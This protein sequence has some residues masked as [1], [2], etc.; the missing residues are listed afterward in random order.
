[1]PSLRHGLRPLN[2]DGDVLK[3]V[4]DVKGFE[5]IEIYVEHMTDS[6]I[7]AQGQGRLWKL[8]LE[9]K[10]EVKSGLHVLVVLFSDY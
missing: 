5:I 2:N 3:F 1:M 7:F 8:G 4:K 10:Y 6:N 9:N